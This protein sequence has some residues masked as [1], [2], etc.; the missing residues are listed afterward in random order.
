[1]GFPEGRKLAKDVNNKLDTST[2]ELVMYINMM[3]G[4]LEDM[5]GILMEIAAKKGEKKYVVSENL[6]QTIHSS[7]EGADFD[8]EN[9]FNAEY[10]GSVKLVVST[11]L[12]SS[13]SLSEVEVTIYKDGINYKSVNYKASELTE[14]KKE[15]TIQVVSG[16]SYYAKI[17]ISVKAVGAAPIYIGPVGIYGSVETIE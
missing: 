14:D 5:C 11:D 2:D 10:N 16:S 7:R 13:S 4:R 3:N 8:T 9:S 1:M 17:D 12:I 15:I 6:L